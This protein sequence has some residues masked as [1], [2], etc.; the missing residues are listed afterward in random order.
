MEERE[1]GEKIG[2]WGEKELN[3]LKK[4]V[5][6][7]SRR[8]R[9]RRRLSQS[10]V[11]GWSPAN[12]WLNESAPSPTPSVSSFRCLCAPLPLFFFWGRGKDGLKKFLL[13][14]VQLRPRCKESTS[15]RAP[16]SPH[17]GRERETTRA[18]SGLGGWGWFRQEA[19]V[20]PQSE[21]RGGGGEGGD[22]H[23]LSFK[24]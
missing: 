15:S 21:V 5:R 23:Y 8:R 11:I 9:S 18:W 3:S 1:R 10:G 19:V 22:S 20:I 6:G 12:F 2:A 7:R 4:R 16:P 14:Q 13:H 17:Q 24:P